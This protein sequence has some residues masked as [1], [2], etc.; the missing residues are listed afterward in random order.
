MVF[1]SPVFLFLF[2]PAALAL[3]FVAPNRLR[4]VVLLIASLFF[5]TWGEPKQFPLMLISIGLN[6]M[7]GLM[8]GAA[9]GKPAGRWVVVLTI[10][11]NIGLLAYYKYSNFLVDALNSLLLFAERPEIVHRT[12]LLPV[13]ISFY[14]FQAMSYVIDV[15]RGEAQAQRN[16]INTAL[17]ISL[18]PQLIAGPIV[19]YVDVAAQIEGRTVTLTDFADG[20]RRFVVGLAKKV[21][22]ANT[23]ATGADAIFD[24][25]DAGLS[26]GIA[27]LGVVCYALQLY[28]DF[29]GYSDMAIGLG[30]M[31]GFRFCE[32][33]NYPYISRSITEF[34]RR[35][36]LSLST[37]FRDYLYVPL[38]GN[39]LGPTR[40]YFN[41]LTVFLLCGLWHGAN[42]TFLLWGAF[43][44]AFLIAERAGLSRL[45]LRLPAVAQHAYALVSVAFGWALFKVETIG[46]AASYWRAM[47]GLCDGASAEPLAE[48]LSSGLVIALVAACIAATPIATRIAEF[49]N[50]LTEG[51]PGAES[52]SPG[53]AATGA[54]SSFATWIDS[55]TAVARVASICGLL[56][57]SAAALMASTYN[58]FIYFRF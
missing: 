34:W 27:W 36:H 41:L 1:S 12:V 4:N 45:L 58:P 5:Y 32:N 43:H 8:A 23:L 6:H 35:W 55:F 44:G 48:Y 50:Q 10:V 13:G 20:V 37:W 14:T 15:Y 16:P 21:L 46:H 11:S 24:L 2:L 19:R 17:Y 42:W 52:A 56:F 33:F 9:R 49:V 29:S 51:R 47:V 40:T 31:F 18:F 28:F 3:H 39:R 54:S 38:G 57:A 25:N 7:L 22:L 30:L 26:F 53:I